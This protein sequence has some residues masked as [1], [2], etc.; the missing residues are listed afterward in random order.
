MHGALCRLLRVSSWLNSSNSSWIQSP[1]F[2]NF[3]VIVPS[4]LLWGIEVFPGLRAHFSIPG[5]TRASDQMSRLPSNWQRCRQVSKQS[6][7]TF[8]P[9][10]ANKALI[11][12]IEWGCNSFGLFCGFIGDRESQPLVLHS[13][14]WAQKCAYCESAH[15][16]LL[17][18]H[19][20]WALTSFIL[21]SMHTLVNLNVSKHIHSEVCHG[22]VLLQQ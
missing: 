19:E 14:I 12:L 16:K 21:T 1:F 13:P 22:K 17:W 7:F 18:I 10:V 8:Q 2:Y 20:M 4:S 15:R 5:F 3:W 11:W 9:Q 6:N